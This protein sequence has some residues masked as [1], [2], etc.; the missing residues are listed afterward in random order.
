MF[1]VCRVLCSP[2]VMVVCFTYVVF[3][4]VFH[5]LFRLERLFVAFGSGVVFVAH[6]KIAFVSCMEGL[7]YFEVYGVLFGSVT[8]WAQEL[9]LF[10]ACC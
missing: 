8:F 3:Y 7:P 10:M 9:A 4:R 1:V 6:R 2:V 5:F